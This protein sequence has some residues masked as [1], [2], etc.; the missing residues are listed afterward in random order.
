VYERIVGDE[1][2]EG[3]DSRKEREDQKEQ[4]SELVQDGLLLWLSFFDGDWIDSAA[5]RAALVR[6]RVRASF[7]HGMVQV[8]G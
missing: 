5:S 3:L 7:G 4:L 6:E 8:S 2:P 1:V